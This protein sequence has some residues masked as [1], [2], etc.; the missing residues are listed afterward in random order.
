M[1]R[2]RGDGELASW[3]DQLTSPP[4]IFLLADTAEEREHDSAQHNG[5]GE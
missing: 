3:T 4:V 2:E 5:G 1:G